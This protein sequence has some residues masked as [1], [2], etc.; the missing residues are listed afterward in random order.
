MLEHARPGAAHLAGELEHRRLLV[1]AWLPEIAVL[2]QRAF[3]GGQIWFM[4]RALNTPADHALVMQ[5]LQG[6]RIPVVVFRRPAYDELANEF[7][8]LDAFIKAQFDEVAQWSFGEGDEVHLLMAPTQAT[9]TDA[10]T[11]W[12]CFRS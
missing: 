9:G 2:S 3:A 8:E 1:A 6:Q 11:G 7:P 5:R 12:P 10:K 4:P